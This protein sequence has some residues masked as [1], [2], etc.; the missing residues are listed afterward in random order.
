MKVVSPIFTL[1]SP[2]T[3]HYRWLSNRRMG[4]YVC[5][6]SFIELFDVPEPS[7]RVWFVFS[8]RPS[9]D[10]HK[11]EF[12]RIPFSAD[13]EED[14]FLVYIDQEPYQ[15]THGVRLWVEKHIGINRPVYVRVEYQ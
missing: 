10:S 11:A 5:Y 6:L 12:T 7:R 1:D 9:H 3:K 4:L 14:V 15:L 2:Q 8:D 13:G